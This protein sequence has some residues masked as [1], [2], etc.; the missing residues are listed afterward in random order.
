MKTIDQRID[1]V[2]AKGFC[3][4]SSCRAMLSGLLEGYRD[5]LAAAPKKSTNRL[6]EDLV[7]RIEA[8][9][10]QRLTGHNAGLYTV[11]RL[12]D[13]IAEIEAFDGWI[14]REDAVAAAR[15]AAEKASQ[16][17]DSWSERSWLAGGAQLYGASQ[18]LYKFA[19]DLEKCEIP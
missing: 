18:G 14:Y 9:P 5:D 3:D 19:D 1:E 11:V 8:L 17:G 4:C 13:V 15:E 16:E 10:S 12:S 7:A 6:P 2:I